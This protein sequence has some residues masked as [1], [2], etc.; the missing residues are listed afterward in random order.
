VSQASK[1]RAA[2]ASSSLL[3]KARSGISK[4]LFAGH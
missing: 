3:A 1:D 4:L 2:D